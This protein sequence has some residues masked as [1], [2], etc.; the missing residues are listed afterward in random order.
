MG[1]KISLTPGEKFNRL[2]IID[3]T[4]PTYC[5]ARRFRTIRCLCECGAFVEALLMHVRSGHTKSCG[6]LVAEKVA[7]NAVV[8]GLHRHSAYGSWQ[9][10]MSRC[11][12]PESTSY[13]RYGGRGITV[14][15]RW[16]DVT[17]FI[18]DMGESHVP[19]LSL[20]REDGD[21]DYEPGNVVWATQKVQN[22]NLSRRS[23]NTSGVTGV[24]H[25]AN[26]ST[27]YWVAYWIDLDGKR[28]L[29]YF[30]ILKHGNDEAFRLACETRKTAL[31]EN[32]YSDKHGK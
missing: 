8:H 18:E 28:Q 12:N 15:E 24:R 13:L 4:A 20:E 11:F 6:C 32:D 10:M 29:R 5:G 22:R 27:E 19:G 17:L 7:R 16:R 21:G 2:T 26:K 14:C 3:E 25:H 23:D 31:E 1:Y 30:P 9:S